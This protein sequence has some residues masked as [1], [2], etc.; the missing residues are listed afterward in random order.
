MKKNILLIV[1]ILG[2][3][4]QAQG[5]SPQFTQ[6]SRISMLT[7]PALVGISG[8]KFSS[9]ARSQWSG[10]N[11]GYNTIVIDFE[12]YNEDR[13][14]DNFGFGA[15]MVKDDILGY[16]FY[17]NNLSTISV[18]FGGVFNYNLGH[19]SRSW[20]MRLA[21]AGTL[22]EKS[23]SE[24]TNVI[25]SPD[26]R[27]QHITS[28][29]DV[30]RDNFH[31]S[32]LTG[33]V[34]TGVMFSNKHFQFGL[35][36]YNIYSL[37]YYIDNKDKSIQLRTPLKLSVHFSSIIPIPVNNENE[38]TLISQLLYRNQGTSNQLDINFISSLASSRNMATLY[39]GVGYRG[40]FSRNSLKNEDAI[41]SIL[42]IQWQWE[43]KHRNEKKLSIMFSHDW[44]V[45]DLKENSRGATEI[46]IVLHWNSV[47]CPHP[48]F[49]F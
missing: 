43:T 38:Y 6:F 14:T 31:I 15:V 20:K 42:G 48:I 18:T 33:D 37:M 9:L 16:P 12:H 28:I 30:S 49:N 34:H 5:Q 22:G 44:V 47:E 23:L 8:T 7:N 46:S 26:L 29:A 21:L 45:R 3:S 13:V 11:Q 36:I 24:N 32:R 10:H 27:N 41:T 40:F 1:F 2:A 17:R 19:Y 25:W 39:L 4:V 35:G